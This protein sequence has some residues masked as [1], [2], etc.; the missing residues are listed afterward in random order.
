MARRPHL[1]D[2]VRVAWRVIRFT[3]T[4]S[5]DERHDRG[6][7]RDAASARANRSG[8]CRVP[9]DYLFLGDS[10][11]HSCDSRTW[12]TVPRKKLIGPVLFTYWPPTRLS[13]R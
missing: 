5:D 4:S 3:A 2:E 11:A 7:D 1:D 12:G 9:S 10:R 8:C 13:L 6:L